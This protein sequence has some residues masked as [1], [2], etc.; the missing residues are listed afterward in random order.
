ML[1]LNPARL[2]TKL[3]AIIRLTQTH[4]DL[5]DTPIEP[6]CLTKGSRA[7]TSSPH[8]VSVDL[9]RID[10]TVVAVDSPTNGLGSLH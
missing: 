7:P 5:P 4:I 10:V 9:D 3:L 6:L 1:T 2:Y 8:L